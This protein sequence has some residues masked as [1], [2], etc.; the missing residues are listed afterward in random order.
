MIFYLAVIMGLLSVYLVLSAFKPLT[1]GTVLTAEEWERLED[2]TL[3]L[4]GRRDRVF[5][6]IRELEFE[7]ALNKVDPIEYENMRRRYEDEALEIMSELQAAL[8]AYG[9]RIDHEIESVLARAS[10]QKGMSTSAKAKVSPDTVIESK[11]AKIETRLPDSA[12]DASKCR[13]CGA[14]MMP[15]SLFCD[16]CGKKQ[17]R[18]CSVCNHANR[19]NARFC[20]ACGVA[21]SEGA[22]AA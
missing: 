2:E 17:V 8:D 20:K 10:R 6:E 14:S 21:L 12:A 18:Y 19:I 7:S 22:P 9:T 4:L 1:E 11:T 13:D 15:G 5:A 16:H 3:H